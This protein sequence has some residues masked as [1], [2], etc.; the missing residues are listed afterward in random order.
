MSPTKPPAVPGARLGGR[1][2]RAGERLGLAHQRAQIGVFPLLDPP[3]RQ[4]LRFE[5]AER[6]L[7][8]RHDL[9]VARQLALR[10]RIASASASS[11]AVFTVRISAFM[12]YAASSWNCA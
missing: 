11:A 7:A 3:V 6:R 8:Q 12:H 4:A 2:G 5:P 9:A 1:V 10:G